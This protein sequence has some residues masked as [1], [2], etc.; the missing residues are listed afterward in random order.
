[1]AQIG[2]IRRLGLSARSARAGKFLLRE[3]KARIPRKPPVEVEV[4]GLGLTVGVELRL[5]GGA[6]ASLIALDVVKKLLRA[7]FIVLPEGPP[8]NIISFTPPLT[9]TRAQISGAV[10]ALAQALR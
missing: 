5:P 7:G 4:R 10:R 3:L 1:L 8:S 2:E 6:P 9:I